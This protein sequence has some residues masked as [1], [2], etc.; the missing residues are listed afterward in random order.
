M[1][2]WP[3]CD[4]GSS[5]A[6]QR[7]DIDVVNIAKMGRALAGRAN[8]GR[9]ARLYRLA[10]CESRSLERVFSL[11]LQEIVVVDV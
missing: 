8:A 4:D 5:L 2:E 9:F 1:K 10:N 7:S 6:S 3:I 11:A